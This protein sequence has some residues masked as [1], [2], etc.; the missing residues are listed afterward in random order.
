MGALFLDL[1]LV[2]VVT[3][4]LMKGLWGDRDTGGLPL[5]W[6]AVYG[7][8]MWKLKGTTVGGSVCG[9]HLV[10]LDGKAVDWS[11]SIMR[12]LGCFLSLIVGGLGFIWIAIDQDGQAWHDKVAGTV[13]VRTPK[14]T[15]IV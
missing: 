14:G 15:P 8:V 5:L 10:R 2:L 1:L 11:T 7:A 6:L 4:I 9:L 13:V 12:A 3:H